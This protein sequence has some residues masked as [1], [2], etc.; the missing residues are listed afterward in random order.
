MGEKVLRWAAYIR[1]Q[2]AVAEAIARKEYEDLTP[3]AVGV[4]DEF[5]ALMDEVGIDGKHSYE[6]AIKPAAEAQAAWGGRIAILGGVDVDVLGQQV[7]LAPA[8]D[9]E[10]GHAQ[11]G[12]A[13]G[14]IVL[15]LDLGR[16]DA[17]G[18]IL[19]EIG[20]FGH[21]LDP[22]PGADAVMAIRRIV[23]E[24]DSALTPRRLVPPMSV[25]RRFAEPVARKD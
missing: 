18:Q 11:L 6:D 17:R 10:G 2:V 5:F 1:N 22:L 12:R 20:A 14:G 13:P 9:D 21:F 16:Q 8:R 3:T 19:R 4:V 7:E 15:L 24:A 25:E 23:G